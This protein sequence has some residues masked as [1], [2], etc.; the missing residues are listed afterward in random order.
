MP[1]HPKM[2]R[3]FAEYTYQLC[4]EL[5]SHRKEKLMRLLAAS[6]LMGLLLLNTPAAA[7]F[8]SCSCAADDGSCSASISCAGGCIAIC[9]S[10]GCR[11]VC[12]GGYAGFMDYMMPISMS[13]THSNSKQVAD[14]LAH[15]TGQPVVITP[16]KAGDT[17]TLDLKKAALWDVLELLS[18]SGKIEIGGEDFAKLQNIR[19]ALV[20]GEKM[21][22]CI[23]STSVQRVLDELTSLSGLRIH[24]SSGDPK[25]VVSLALKDATLDDILAQL[26]SQSSV[27]IS[28]N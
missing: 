17:I 25:T 3:Y 23:H 18:A 11:A 7:T 4:E 26:S 24:A 22:V 19:K 8:E 27:E 21:T 15:I 9:P 28:K 10:G 5:T 6:L 20:S 14:E 13:Q 12:S 1:R 2:V 16:F